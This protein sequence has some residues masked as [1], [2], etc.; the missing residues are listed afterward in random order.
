MKMGNGPNKHLSGWEAAASP[1]AWNTYLVL[2]KCTC[3]EAQVQT[4]VF[5]LLE[6][7]TTPGTTS[8][9]SLQFSK[10]FLQTKK[11]ECS[12]WA[13][14]FLSTTEGTMRTARLNTV[15]WPDCCLA[16]ISVSEKPPW[17]S[18]NL[19]EVCLHQV[20]NFEHMPQALHLS[21]NCH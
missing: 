8:L 17:L 7:I 10:T 3:V 14:I 18:G 12:F 9:E 15:M 20:C 13:W 4:H 5:F 1:S 19:P 2:L 21:R 16:V 6:V 11:C